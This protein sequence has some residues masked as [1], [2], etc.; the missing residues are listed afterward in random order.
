MSGRDPDERAQR[1]RRLDAVLAAVPGRAEH[2]RDLPEIVD[3]E[4]WPPRGTPRP[5]CPVP[6]ASD[7]KQ[8]LQLLR[9]RRLGDAAVSDAEQLD[10]A[11]QRRLL[12]LAERAD[13]VVRGGEVLVAIELAARQRHEVRRVQPRVLRVDRD[14]HLHDV[15][16]GQPIEDHR[17]HGEVSPPNCSIPACSASSRCWPSIARSTPSRS[18]TFSMPSDGSGLDR[19]ELQR[20]V[21]R[22]DDGAGNRRQ[23]A[24]LPALLVVRDQLVDL[25][26]DDLALVGLLVRRDAALEQI[27]PHLRLPRAPRTPAPPPCSP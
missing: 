24:R 21:A 10:L 13:D 5:C 19:L 9:E 14:E 22:D 16:F 11:V 26:A 20:L 25:P 27:P 6:N 7:G 4:P 18:G 3:E 12:L 15:I 23:I 1:R 2:D 8:L 17:R